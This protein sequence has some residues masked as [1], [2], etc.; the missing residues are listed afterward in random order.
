MIIQTYLSESIFRNFT[1]FDILKRQK[2]YKA[3]IIFA[4][5]LSISALICFIMKRVDGAVLLGT[6]LLI[7]GLGMPLVYFSTF[8]LSLRKQVKLQHLN[9][10]R[11]VYTLEL[12]DKEDGIHIENG[13]EE[14]TYKWS[15]A[16]KAYNAKDC[17]YL[18]LTSDRAFLLP[19]SCLK[20][21]ET[22]LWALLQ[23][24][25]GNEKCQVLK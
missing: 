19:K 13:K 6:V 1:L 20:E 18:Y 2:S 8:F 11:L 24:R 12:S 14:A 9:P 7:V 10:P 21:E 17:Y 16:F 22:A 25:L 3:P 4:S 23:K 15:K 5:I